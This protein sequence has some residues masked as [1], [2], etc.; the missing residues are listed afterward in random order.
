MGMPQLRKPGSEPYVCGEKDLRVYRNT[1]LESRQDS[2]NKGQ[3]TAF[4]EFVPLL[5]SGERGDG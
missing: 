2:G 1:V 4:V 5:F 3:S